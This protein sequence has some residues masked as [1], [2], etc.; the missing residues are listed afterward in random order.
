MHECTE[1]AT[2]LHD[3]RAVFQGEEADHAVN[4][5]YD[6]HAQRAEE[7]QLLAWHQSQTHEMQLH[8][9]SNM[10]TEVGNKLKLCAT[11]ASSN[12]TQSLSSWVC[13]K[14]MSSFLCASKPA[15]MKMI[16][17][18]KRATAG[19]ILSRHAR[20]HM[21]TWAPGPGIPTLIIRGPSPWGAASAPNSLSGSSTMSSCT[22]LRVR[23]C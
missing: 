11:S 2:L 20:F 21:G 13:L 15:D 7:L 14:L 18:L 9:L 5:A 19:K 1:N 23:Q 3:C 22:R 6:V 17:G 8:M 12:V 10:A 4:Q 16:S